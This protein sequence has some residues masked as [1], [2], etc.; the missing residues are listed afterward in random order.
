MCV[1]VVCSSLF[2]SP[3]EVT[4]RQEDG[5]QGLQLACNPYA[6]PWTPFAPLCLGLLLFQDPPLA[7]LQSFG[8]LDSEGTNVVPSW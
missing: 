3:R 7:R 1:C 5:A 8:R 2:G 4:P 6:R